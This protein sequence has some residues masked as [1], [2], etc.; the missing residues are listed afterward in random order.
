MSKKKL[1]HFLKRVISLWLLENKITS[2]GKISHFEI[3]ITKTRW[4]E[5]MSCSKW[6]KRAR[7]FLVVWVLSYSVKWMKYGTFKG[8]KKTVFGSSTHKS[9]YRSIFFISSVFIANQQLLLEE[10]DFRFNCLRH[11]SNAII[12]ISISLKW[13]DYRTYGMRT[14][15]VIIG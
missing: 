1:P 3:A 8:N 14:V 5:Q 13:I 7:I 6:E 2:G 10:V 12:W 9:H 11:R 15:N 4:F